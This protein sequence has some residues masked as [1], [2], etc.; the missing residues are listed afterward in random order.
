VP[1]FMSFDDL[2]SISKLSFH[3]TKD[4]VDNDLGGRGRSFSFTKASNTESLLGDAGLSTPISTMSAP[5]FSPRGK[6]M[7][8]SDPLTPISL[9]FG[10]LFIPETPI[11]YDWC[12]I[13]KYTPGDNAPSEWLRGFIVLLSDGP[14]YIYPS[15]DVSDR[16]AFIFS[17][18]LLRDSSITYIKQSGSLEN[19]IEVAMDDTIWIIQSESEEASEALLDIIKVFYHTCRI[20]INFIYI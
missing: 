16:N 4:E 8:P 7:T 9:S 15:D 11:H 3:S 6:T 17:C 1:S 19:A 18:N 5:F 2:D 12:S 20:H 14:L 13:K 10:H